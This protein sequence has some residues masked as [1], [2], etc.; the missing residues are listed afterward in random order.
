[1]HVDIDL[2]WMLIW[3]FIIS[4]RV[5]NVISDC[6]TM[7]HGVVYHTTFILCVQ[8][9]AMLVYCDVWVISYTVWPVHCVVKSKKHSLTNWI[10]L[11]LPRST[12]YSCYFWL[13]F[14]WK[15]SI[16]SPRDGKVKAIE[17]LA[18]V[19]GFQKPA[20]CGTTWS[21]SSD[22]NTSPPR[23]I[24]FIQTKGQKWDFLPQHGPD[25]SFAITNML[26][27]TSSFWCEI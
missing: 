27:C 25:G 16:I 20:V 24:R 15:F 3:M 11:S 26:Q 12:C 7:L 9:N 5:L 1:M 14:I 8:V 2:M 10:S 19:V 21:I 4:G 17:S 22:W 6:C 18:V 13:T 23:I